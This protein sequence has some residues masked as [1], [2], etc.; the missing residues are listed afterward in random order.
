LNAPI[1]FHVVTLL[2]I[3]VL[4]FLNCKEKEDIFSDPL[5]FLET[6]EIPQYIQKLPYYGI[7]GQN[8]LKD[9]DRGKTMEIGGVYGKGMSFS[10]IRIFNDTGLFY[11]PLDRELSCTQ[12][13]SLIRIRG[14]VSKESEPFLSGIE[15]ISV[16]DIGDLKDIVEKKYRSLVGK[17]SDKVHRSESKLDLTSLEEFHCA[18]S[19]S[20]IL[21]FGR[22]YDLMYEFDIGVLIRMNCSSS[23]F[24]K[25]YAREFFKGE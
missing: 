15:V 8:Y 10:F 11:I 25:I 2:L 24:K 22:T 3:S 13:R 23:D 19:D 16:V 9:S 17:I 5:D 1:R 20:A 7:N 12:E 6:K 18:A 4:L 21:V 14:V